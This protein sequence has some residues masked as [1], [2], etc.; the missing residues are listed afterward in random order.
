MKQQIRKIVVVSLAFLLGIGS[1]F[2]QKK[3]KKIVEKRHEIMLCGGG[4]LSSLQYHVNTGKQSMGLGGQ[5]GFGYN[6]FFIPKL[7]LGTGV[8]FVLYTASFTMKNTSI[9][10][11]TVDFE[12]SIFEFRSTMDA[13]KENQM[14]V[15]L[16]VP[17]M[18]QFQTGAKHQFYAAAGG[19]VGLPL[20]VKYNSS[21]T[22]IQNSGYYEEEDYE[23]TTQ[24][25]MGFGK[26]KGSSG[27]L[28]LKIAF[29]A[30][31][32]TGAKLAMKDGYTLYVGTYVDYGLNNIANQPSE[33]LQFL[34]YN[35]TRPSDFRINSVI[36]S[37]HSQ[38]GT[39]QAF[40]SKVTTLAAGIK[41]RLA[42]P[43]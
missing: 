25:F 7:G 38:N 24:T 18:L 9:R 20:S 11:K 5:I 37:Q 12:N 33:P 30:S 36:E 27:D 23:Y 40:T 6:F 2:A 8:E 22:I 1:L 21:K 29:F 34:S 17:L 39:L 26:F 14:A 10:Y 35:K 32:E 42:F 43:K 15:M 31:M 41:V 16:Q 4:G 13:Y 19:K 3:Q 28:S